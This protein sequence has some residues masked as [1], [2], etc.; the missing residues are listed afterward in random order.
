MKQRYTDKIN[1]IASV[2]LFLLSYFVG[3]FQEYVLFRHHHQH[4][5]LF[6]DY[7]YHYYHWILT[8]VNENH[9]DDDDGD[10]LEIENENDDDEI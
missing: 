2:Y 6:D 4:G 10:E 3:Y 1:V 5:D 7:Y 9:V 8:Q